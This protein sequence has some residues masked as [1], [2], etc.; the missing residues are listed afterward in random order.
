MENKDFLSVYPYSFTEAKHLN[1]LDRWKESHKENVACKSAIEEAI[2][3]GFDGMHLSSD[4]AKSI[5][6]QFGYHRTAYD[7]LPIVFLSQI[8][9]QLKIMKYFVKSQYSCEL[10]LHLKTLYQKETLVSI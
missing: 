9:L 4:C 6:T 7:Y 5:I 8:P 10:L 1:E 3:I 2:R